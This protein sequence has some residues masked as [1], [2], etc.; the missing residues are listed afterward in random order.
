[1]AIRKMFQIKAEFN[2]SLMRLVSN[3][4]CP[5]IKHEIEQTNPDHMSVTVLFLCIN[6]AL[7][8]TKMNI[9]SQYMF[10]EF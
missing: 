10:Y 8:E 6:S 1:M 2:R 3:Y 5:H 4:T 9:Y 7:L